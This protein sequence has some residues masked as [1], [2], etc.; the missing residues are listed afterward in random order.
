MSVHPLVEVLGFPGCPNVEPVLDLVAVAAAA[1]G[2]EPEVRVVNVESR[3]AVE[4]LR[5]LGSPS[6]RVG[7]RDVEPGAEERGVFAYA[8][9]VYETSG[10][11]H[12]VPD[13]GWIAA[14][15]TA[16]G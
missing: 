13:A 3:K 8:C 11:R 12:G 2:V 6:V 5:F 10:G 7:G 16:G 15:L 1:A 14:A 4:S 9:R